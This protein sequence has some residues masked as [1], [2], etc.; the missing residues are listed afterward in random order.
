MPSWRAPAM[1]IVSRMCS[2]STGSSPVPVATA[3]TSSS[4]DCSKAMRV[5]SLRLGLAI[6]WDGSKAFSRWR[7]LTAT[8]NM[9]RQAPPALYFTPLAVLVRTSRPAA[10]RLAALVAALSSARDSM[11]R[12]ASSRWLGW[13]PRA[14]GVTRPASTS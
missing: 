2:S 1:R 4:W 10:S 6:S 5:P 11:W 14:S 12:K 7:S 8:L 9:R 3:H 13:K